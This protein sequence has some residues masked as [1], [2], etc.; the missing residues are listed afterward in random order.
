MAYES[1]R[2][3]VQSAIAAMHRQHGVTSS[4]GSIP[5]RLTNSSTAGALLWQTQHFPHLP[6]IHVKHAFLKRL[7]PIVERTWHVP[8]E[9]MV[10]WH[11]PLKKRVP[12]SLG[13]P[14]K[15][16]SPPAMRGRTG[17]RASCQ[18]LDPED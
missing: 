12:G 14:R 6:A 13:S 5:A 1:I 18:I 9:A 3:T 2:D 16:D 7:D 4:A 15:T 10:E 8:W 11:A 17:S